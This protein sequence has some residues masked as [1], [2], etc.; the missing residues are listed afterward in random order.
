MSLGRAHLL[1]TSL[2]REAT[3]AGIPPTSLNRVGSLRRFVPDIGDAAL[4]AGISTAHQPD[5]LTR[6][7]TLPMVTGVLARTT[8]MASVTTTK[9]RATLFVVAP[10]QVGAGLV[11]HTGSRRHI[12]RLQER[13]ERF[14][15]TFLHGQ[16]RRGG[17][18]LSAPAEEDVYRYLELPLIPPELREGF[19]EV[20]AAE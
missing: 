9:G 13:A 2:I 17:A 16:L 4:L 5:V 8:G 15:L 18:L 6:F 19:D 11:W 7:A 3:R 1:A 20:D 14:G 12:E 10:D